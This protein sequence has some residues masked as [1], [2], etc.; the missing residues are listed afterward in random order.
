MTGHPGQPE[1]E[2]RAVKSNRS[3]GPDGGDPVS[4]E[5]QGAW[6]MTR[7]TVSWIMAVR[8]YGIVTADA[9]F[10]DDDDERRRR[11]SARKLAWTAEPKMPPAGHRRRGTYREVNGRGQRA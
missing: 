4:D 2:A 9:M 3:A 6:E 11:R 7:G 10:P 1:P 5:H 8:E